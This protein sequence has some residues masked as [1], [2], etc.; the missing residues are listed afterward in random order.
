M[1][2]VQKGSVKIGILIVLLVA[3]AFGLYT[4]AKNREA[5]ETATASVLLT[6]QAEGGLCVYGLCGSTITLREDGAYEYVIGQTAPKRGSVSAAQVAALNQMID[7]TNFAQIKSVPFT[8]TCPIAYD[9]S[10]Y[11]YT[12]ST[13]NGT[14]RID[15]CETAVDIESPLFMQIEQI[16][17]EIVNSHSI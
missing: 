12:F 1:K 17:T 11:V 14:E 10:K 4:Y 5:R 8:E 6:I 2:N 15:S 16:Q 7:T 13:P 3:L 9:G